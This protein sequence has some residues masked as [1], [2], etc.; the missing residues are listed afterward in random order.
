MLIDR[1][2]IHS[3][4]FS[5]QILAYLSPQDLLVFCR[6]CSLWNKAGNQD[7]LW[8]E[9]YRTYLGGPL[10]SQFPYSSPLSPLPIASFKQLYLLGWAKLSQPLDTTQTV[11][12][13]PDIYYAIVTLKQKE[14]ARVAQAIRCNFPQYVINRPEELK[15]LGELVIWDCTLIGIGIG[16]SHNLEMIQLL[17]TLE[18]FQTL[19][20]WRRQHSISLA[21]FFVGMYINTNKDKDKGKDKNNNKMRSLLRSLRRNAPIR[22]FV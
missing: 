21:A 2:F 17:F 10:P 6:V 14:L 18:M 11:I 22:I 20:D 7:K 19:T 3:L 5:P 1:H 8:R 9:H 15:K 13:V 16:Y 4:P 12:N